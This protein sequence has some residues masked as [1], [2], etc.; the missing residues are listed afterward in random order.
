MPQPFQ[1]LATPVFFPETSSVSH[2]AWFSTPPP[3][4]FP[5]FGSQGPNLKNQCGGAQ[6]CLPPPTS[7]PSP[8]RI[9]KGS[10]L[11]H[12]LALWAWRRLV[13]LCRFIF[14]EQIRSGCEFAFRL[15][16]VLR[17]FSL[18]LMRRHQ[19][20]TLPNS[21]LLEASRPYTGISIQD[22]AY[23]DTAA[24]RFPW[25]APGESAPTLGNSYALF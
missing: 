13:D 25:P 9:W 22:L 6:L 17:P 1:A 11:C 12:V 21:F 15:L 20:C 23:G 10:G 19:I 2:P 14:S 3:A 7:S 8:P 5:R 24:T 4:F 18:H 16:S